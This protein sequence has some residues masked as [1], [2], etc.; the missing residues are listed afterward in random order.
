MIERQKRFAE[1]YLIDL[2]ATRAYKAAYPNVKKDETAAAAAARLLKNVKVKAYIDEQM[3]KRA[4][5]TEVTQDKVV[6]ELAKIGFARITDFVEIDSQN[7]VIIRSTDKMDENKIGAIA[8]IKEGQNGIEVK[9]NDKVKALE[10]L[11]RH[12]GMWND[13]QE[14]TATI[15]YE[16]YIKNLPSDSGF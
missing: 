4:K 15:S 5:R 7:N 3:Q 8:G 2:N 11:G 14:I 16:D 6:A 9:M 10:L 13:K 1:E 12:L